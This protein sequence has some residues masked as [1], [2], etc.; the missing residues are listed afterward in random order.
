MKNNRIN[1]LHHKFKHWMGFHRAVTLAV[2]VAVG[3][4]LGV[5]IPSGIPRAQNPPS[6]TRVAVVKSLDLPQYNS[7]YQ[8]FINALT[9]A[10][11]E[12]VPTTLTLSNDGEVGAPLRDLVGTHPDL[13][14]ALGTRAAREVSSL[15]KTIP[16]IY[17]MVL[18][19]PGSDG[20]ESGL[21][22]QSNLTGASLNIPLYVQLD[23]IRSL[24]P[25]ARKV[26]IISDPSRT[27][28]IVDSATAIAAV[29]DIKVCV[30]W[31]NGESDIPNAIRAITDS[32]DVLWMIPD[33]TVITP[34][35]SRF[36]IFELIKAGVPIMGLSSAYVKAG[37]VIALDCDYED[38]GRQAGELAVR[39]LAGQSPSTLAETHPRMFTLALNG[40]V[41]EHL[42]LD[43]DEAAVGKMHVI[44]F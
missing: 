33:Q 17:S 23:H 32:I 7:A 6:R 2:I 30:Q 43:L 29:H 19:A 13:I 15:E 26:G 1:L 14:L 40:K 34:R 36:I 27:K 8:G 28:D 3:T 21:T 9:S 25:T 39:I 38:I 18:N 20:E 44:T 16:I 42:R 10:G 24:F 41:R 11:H 37:A 31:V 12:P 4:G 5:V 35:S 22:A